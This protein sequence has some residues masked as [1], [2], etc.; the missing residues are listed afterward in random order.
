[1]IVTPWEKLRSFFYHPLLDSYVAPGGEEKRK[2]FL[3]TFWINFKYA[4]PIF[5][6]FLSNIFIFHIFNENT[7]FCNYLDLFLTL[8]SRIS[9]MRTTS[10]VLKITNNK[11]NVLL[12]CL[13]WVIGTIIGVNKLGNFFKVTVLKKSHYTC[14]YQTLRKIKVLAH[15]TG[16]SPIKRIILAPWGTNLEKL[17]W[18]YSEY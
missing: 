9:F 18:K 7:N 8:Q 4:N 5:D 12:T 17:E 1:M 2:K 14:S 3:I 16:G 11:E 6:N 10:F 15:P 13:N